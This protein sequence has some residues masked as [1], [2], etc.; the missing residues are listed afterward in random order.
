MKNKIMAVKLNVFNETV[1]RKARNA[2]GNNAFPSPIGISTVLK[3]TWKR[4]RI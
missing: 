4:V 2:G 1:K 3:M